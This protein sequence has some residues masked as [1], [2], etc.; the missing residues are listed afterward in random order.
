MNLGGSGAALA[1]Q[2]TLWSRISS[3][4]AK[5]YRLKKGAVARF[6]VGFISFG[7]AVWGRVTAPRPGF[8]KSW[9]YFA[10]CAPRGYAHD[11][12]LAAAITKGAEA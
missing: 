11:L 10:D 3:K 7:R 2:G 12:L 8:D 4:A 6:P 9:G 1:P 5:A